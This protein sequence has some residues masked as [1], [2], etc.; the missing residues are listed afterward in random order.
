MRPLPAL[1]IY[2][3]VIFLGGALVAP[4]LYWL[5]QSFA[6]TFPHLASSPFHRFVNRSL[7]GLAL[8]GLWPLLRALGARSWRDLGLVNPARQGRKLGAGFAVGF[9]SLAIVAL[10]ALGTGARAL[11]ENQAHL[12]RNLLGAALTAVVVAVLEEILFR[13]ALFGTLRK[14]MNW[15]WALVISSMIY[16]LAHFMESSRLTGPVLWHSG[17][18]LLPRM[19]RGLG[20]WQDLVPG[21][22]NLTLA[23]ALLALAYQRTGNL[24]FSIGLHAGWIFWLKSYGVFTQGVP[25]ANAWVWGGAKLIDGWMALLVLSTTL[26]VFLCLPFQSKSPA[27]SETA[28]APA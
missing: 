18:D 12:T 21:F 11:T 9:G 28:K 3:I 17:F 14:V 2:I 22:F 5:T 4:W 23:G 25:G 19:L 8:I 15:G 16:A 24:Y 6:P 7:L 20:N 27:S 26:V 13:G 10:T 1:G